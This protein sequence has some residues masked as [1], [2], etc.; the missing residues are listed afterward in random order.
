M[1]SPRNVC[2][3][4]RHKWKVKGWAEE[5]PKCGHTNV[6][7]TDHAP[8]L[9]GPVAIIL[10]VVVAGAWWLGYVPDEAKKAVEST[11]DN[12]RKEVE[13]HVPD[14]DAPETQPKL[15][16][17][18]K[19]AKPPTPKPTATPTRTPTPDP[20]PLNEAP[21][22]PLPKVVVSSKSGAA[23]SNTYFVKGKVKNTGGADANGVTVKVTFRDV[24]GKKIA[25]V[26]ARCKTE[27]A[28]GK[29]TKF[30]AAVAGEQAAKV[31]GFTVEADWD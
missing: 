1:G 11:V 22:I 15:K 6:G 24:A 23:T 10:I 9:A 26:E 28:A 2:H 31:D 8:G 4:C 25:A 30:E 12:V 17:N 18:P 5:C 7:P 16:N 13:K 14:D 29:T 21:K 3:R 27:L 20:E 19:N